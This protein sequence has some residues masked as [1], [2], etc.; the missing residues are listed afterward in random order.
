MSTDPM[1]AAALRFVRA[2]WYARLWRWYL[3]VTGY[4]AAVERRPMFQSTVFPDDR[5]LEA[6]K[7]CSCGLCDLRRLP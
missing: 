5:S 1:M 7:R 4:A 2:P 3:R 6:G